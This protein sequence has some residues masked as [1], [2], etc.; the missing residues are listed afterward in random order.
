MKIMAIILSCLDDVSLKG[1]HEFSKQF[2]AKFAQSN[3]QVHIAIVSHHG[4][5]I[6][7]D[8]YF[9][10]SDKQFAKFL[11]SIA[12]EKRAVI[13]ACG[14]D[15]KEYHIKG[16]DY[17]IIPS[18]DGSTQAIDSLSPK[19]LPA[20]AEAIDWMRESGDPAVIRNDFDQVSIANKETN[21]ITGAIFDKILSSY[22]THVPIPEDT[23]HLPVV[24]TPLQT[25]SPKNP[26]V[27]KR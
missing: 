23:Y 18:P 13:F 1:L 25:P 2:N 16:F 10:Y 4:N 15:S 11:E 19:F 3:P 5:H 24:V 21:E 6:Y 14:P 22:Y 8:N 27:L 26:S 7:A 12:G 20:Y 17:V 9:E